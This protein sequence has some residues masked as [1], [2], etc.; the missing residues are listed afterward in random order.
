[1]RPVESIYDVP[2]FIKK[3]K[4]QKKNYFTNFFPDLTKI[5]LWI[6]SGVFDFEDLG[7][8]IFLYRRNQ[9]F[10]NLFFIS[11][12]INELSD[13]L[14][15]IL[16][17]YPYEIFIAD[18]VGKS[19]SDGVLVS[20]FKEKGFFPYVHLTRMSRIV[21]P[22]SNEQVLSPFTNYCTRDHMEEINRLLQCYFDPYAEQLP[23]MEEIQSWIDNNAILIYSDDRKTIQGFVI[24]ELTGQTSYLRYWFVHPDYREKKIGSL[25]LRNFFYESR[26]TKRQLFW[27]IESN[28]NAI[29]RYIHYGFKPEELFDI[30]MINKNIHYEGKNN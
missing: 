28:D 4:E 16:K 30:V 17:K 24:F 2:V 7:E 26:D 27:V 18:I 23:L 20:T 6:T 10:N 29:K 22:D 19:L 21:T 8:T 13:N 11:C 14:E 9:G 3:I 12:G 1:M 5:Q 15:F 25:L